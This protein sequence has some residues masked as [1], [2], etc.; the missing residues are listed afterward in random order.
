MKVNLE[1][2]LKL[3]TLPR[4]LG[5]H[6]EL[7]EPVIARDGRFGP[8]FSVVRD[9]QSLGCLSPI[10]VTFE[11]ALH[12]LAQPK[13]LGRGRACGGQER[14][15]QDHGSLSPVTGNPLQV[16]D[17]RYWSLRNRW[18]N[19][20]QRSERHER[21]RIDAHPSPRFASSRAALGGSKKKKVAKA[22]AK[23]VAKKAEPKAAKKAPAK[24]KA[25]KK[26]SK[27]KS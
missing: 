27:K 1:I 23:K 17:G 13:T 3:L 20:C 25:A 19:Q 21:R 18:R 22:G 11:E 24:K 6:P 16:L 5:V 15:H 8:T 7:N 9:S 10:E 14:T 26:A 12:L 2:A 4:T